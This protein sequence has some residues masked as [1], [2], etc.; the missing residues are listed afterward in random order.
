VTVLREEGLK[1]LWFKVLGETVYRRLTLVE[2]SLAST[3]P[4][5]EPGIALSFDFV[6]AVPDTLTELRD[7][8]TDAEI[9]RRLARGDRCFVAWHEGRIVSARWLAADRAWIEYL[10]RDLDLLPGET[11][12]YETYTA[13][14]YRG[15]SIS[16][17]AGTRLAH[18]LAAEGLRRI[19]GGIVPENGPALRTA[20]KTGYREA[21]RTGYVRFGPWRHDFTRRRR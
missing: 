15:L 16:A 6:E 5:R 3:P 14:E 11:Y 12:L 13:P 10:G 8:L 18:L 4:L 7:D 1:V 20:A 21:G 19:V 2:L 17:A 9:E